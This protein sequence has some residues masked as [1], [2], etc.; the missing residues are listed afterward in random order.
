MSWVQNI[1]L[2]TRLYDRDNVEAFATWLR[3][4]PQEYLDRK[5]W[6]AEDFEPA[7]GAAGA[8]GAHVGGTAGW[9]PVGEEIPQG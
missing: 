7:A 3:E 4:R 8:G 1:M 2:S 9:M 6:R 5:R